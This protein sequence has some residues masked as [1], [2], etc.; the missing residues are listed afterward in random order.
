[1]TRHES[2][3][4]EARVSRQALVVRFPYRRTSYLKIVFA[5]TVTVITFAKVRISEHN[6]KQKTIFFVFIVERKY[7]RRSQSTKI[8]HTNKQNRIKLSFCVHFLS[9]IDSEG[10]DS[11]VVNGFLGASKSPAIRGTLFSFR[12]LDGDP[13]GFAFEV[14]VRFG[15]VTMMCHFCFQQFDYLLGAVEVGIAQY[16]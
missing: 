6:T 15:T 5:I 2:S 8:I 10:A 7:F 4:C 11:V 9:F 3:F 14:V 13:D 12:L 16:A 1:M